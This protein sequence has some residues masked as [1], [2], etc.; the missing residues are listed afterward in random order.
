MAIEMSDR[1]LLVK[2]SGGDLN[3]MLQLSYTSLFCLESSVAR[4]QI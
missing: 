3:V 4:L 2:I 1:E